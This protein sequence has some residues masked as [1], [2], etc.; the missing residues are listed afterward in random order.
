M[1]NSR[2]IL[3]AFLSSYP[4][5]WAVNRRSKLYLSPLPTLTPSPA[6]HEIK[7]DARI[8]GAQPSSLV[9]LA[10]TSSPLTSSIRDWLLVPPASAA[11]PPTQADIQLLNR[12]LETFYSNA[13]YPKALDLLS[14]TVDRWIEQPADE[15]ASLYRIRADCYMAL[16]QPNKAV[17][18]YSQAINLLQTPEAKDAADPNE[19][20]AALL[21]RARAQRSLSSTNTGQ[22]VDWNQAA[23]D[24]KQS[25][26]L[27]SREE[28]DTVEELIEDGAQRNPFAA[29]EWGTSLRAAGRYD[30]AAQAHQ[31]A[32]Q[33]FAQ[34]GDT[35]RS[36]I[37][38]LPTCFA[39]PQSFGSADAAQMPSGPP[40]PP[41]PGI[42][43]APVPSGRADPCS[44]P[45]RT[46]RHHLASAR[47]AQ[48]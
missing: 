15:R 10:T 11:E 39:R 16:Q 7:G 6:I 47:Q 25:F 43:Q 35:A 29:W 30:E 24:Y 44:A 38:S 37:V 45:P 13:E 26:Q 20:P 14:Q 34:I 17:E 3:A 12:A 2:W 42:P 19:L 40:G 5:E 4:E 21:G 36:V 8:T 9:S 23:S 22:P 46:Q 1:K 28:W 31:L 27:S 41:P 32:S 33:S 48:E 18:D